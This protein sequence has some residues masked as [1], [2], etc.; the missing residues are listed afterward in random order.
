MAS[1][2]YRAPHENSIPGIDR[3]NSVNRNE[4]ARV[5]FKGIDMI[6]GEKT[7]A[8]VHGAALMFLAVCARIGVEPRGCLER[9]ERILNSRFDAYDHKANTHFSALASYVDHL[10]DP[11][12]S[13]GLR[14]QDQNFSW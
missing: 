8:Q 10:H 2:G 11:V 4:V 12:K 13:I 1:K 5:A 6:E 9:A 14:H 7:E 3:L